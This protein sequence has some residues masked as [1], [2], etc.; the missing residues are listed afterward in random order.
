M[1]HIVLITPHG[2]AKPRGP[3]TKVAHGAAPGTSAVDVVVGKPATVQQ[4]ETQGDKG[5]CFCKGDAAVGHPQAGAQTQRPGGELESL[6]GVGWGGKWVG[7][8]VFEGL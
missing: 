1:V 3:P 5:K 7:T 4:A 8:G 6:W 2:C